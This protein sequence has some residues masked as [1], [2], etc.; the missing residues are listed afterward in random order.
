MALRRGTSECYKSAEREING[1]VPL[2]EPRALAMDRRVIFRCKENND[3]PFDRGQEV[4]F[5]VARM[6]R[7]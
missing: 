2:D 4:G 6:V 7:A 3:G 1:V 5:F